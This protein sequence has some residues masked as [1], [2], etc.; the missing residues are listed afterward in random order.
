MSRLFSW[1]SRNPSSSGH[2]EVTAIRTFIYT[3]SGVLAPRPVP[4]IPQYATPSAIRVAGGKMGTN[5]TTRVSC[6]V[7]ACQLGIAREPLKTQTQ[8]YLDLLAG[9]SSERL[10]PII[11]N[12]GARIRPRPQF[13]LQPPS[14]R[15][16]SPRPAA[17]VPPAQVRGFG[18]V[19]L[20][21]MLG[22]L[23]VALS[24]DIRPVFIFGNALKPDISV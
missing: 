7:C 4:Q 5:I 16:L 9:Y 2:D 14:G 8:A 21:S 6:H 18:L 13:R 12:P 24:A 20:A 3:I 17:P 1:R 15:P 10:F 19:F 23:T 22:T 11:D